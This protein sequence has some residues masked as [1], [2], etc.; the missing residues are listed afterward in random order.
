MT[1]F[2]KFEHPQ[3]I[4]LAFLTVNEFMRT[5]NG[6]KPRPWNRQDA[7]EFLKLAKEVAEKS[8]NGLEV[9]ESL[10]KKFSFVCS[11][12]L[13]PVCAAIGGLV[14]QEVLKACSGK[15]MPIRQWLHFDALECLP[16][17][18]LS[19]EDCTP[20]GNRYDGQ[21]AVFGKEFQ[22]KVIMKL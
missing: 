7:E 15:F 22:K 1:D 10:L 4:Q 19:E 21:V 8:M 3:Q 13:S 2:G 18:E 12:Q 16:D 9:N 5:H 11:G 20:E 6:Q 17:E 14:G